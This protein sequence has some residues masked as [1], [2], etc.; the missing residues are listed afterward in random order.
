[1][2]YIV[3]ILKERTFLIELRQDKD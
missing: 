3:D 1:M 2:I